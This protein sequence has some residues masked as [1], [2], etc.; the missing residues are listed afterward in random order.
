LDQAAGAQIAAKAPGTAAGIEQAAIVLTDAPAR[1]VRVDVLARGA[2]VTRES[3]EKYGRGSAHA[4]SSNRWPQNGAYGVFMV[5]TTP[6]PR[7]VET[8]RH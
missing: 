5:R 2:G 4:H 3:K 1:R 6:F 7:T 8:V